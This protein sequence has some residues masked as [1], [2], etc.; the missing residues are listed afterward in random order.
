MVRGS[1]QR[2]QRSSR[3]GDPVVDQSSRIR[4]SRQ[5]GIASVPPAIARRAARSS[6]V[7]SSTHVAS[8]I[9]GCDDRTPASHA[10]NRPMA[11]GGVRVDDGGRSAA[12]ASR[13]GDGATVAWLD[14][15]FPNHLGQLERSQTASSGPQ[16]S[17]PGPGAPTR[18]DSS[19]SDQLLSQ[20]NHL[21]SQPAHDERNDAQDP[22]SLAHGRLGTSTGAHGTQTT[23]PSWSDGR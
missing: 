11:P 9:C 3:P 7:Q 8:M 12:S 2:R 10:A 5:R 4:R 6:P 20:R 19:A 17:A 23:A 14:A 18:V 16:H 22:D 21:M 13:A 15:Q 1:L